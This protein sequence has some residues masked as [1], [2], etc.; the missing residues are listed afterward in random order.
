MP[1]FLSAAASASPTALALDDG[2][3]GWSYAALE[4][5]V[6]AAAGRLR[7]AAVA[8]RPVA[9][10]SE[11]TGDAVVA[12]HAALAAGA[13]L[14]PL[15]PRLTAEEMRPALETLRPR[16]VLAA[17]EA[18]D[19]ALAAGARPVPLGALEGEG[20]DALAERATA[21]GWPE[22]PPG[23]RVVLWTSGTGGRPRGVA[24]THENLEASIGAA[25]GR[26]ALGPDDR[27]LATL[28]IAH[29]GGLMLVLRAAATRALLI[30]RG[31]FRAGEVSALLDSAGV[32]HASLVPTMLRQLLDLR[33]DESPEA[34]RCLLIG[35]AHCP[36]SLVD[37]ALAAGFPLALT[38]GMTEATSQATTAAPALVR[39]K[40]G[41]VGSP[42]EGVE[43]RIDEAGEVL[44]R[45]ATVAA[46]YLGSELPLLDGEGWLRTGDLGELDSEGHLW[47]T[48]R[49]TDR[50]VTGGVN[51]D[52]LEVEDILRLHAG[53]SDAA[54]VGLPD[55]RWGEV[56]A[57]AVVRLGGAYPDPGELEELARARL[58][59]AKV[60]R[61]WLFLTELPKNQNGKIDRDA[62]RQGFATA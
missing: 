18:W 47:V 52:P 33:G 59:T 35:G 54:V 19:R 39:R 58:T 37:R 53:V 4:Q 13:V 6:S 23:T 17:P 26:L 31:R 2:E 24:L 48:G 38:Y 32:T 34:L 44:L 12:A 62:V 8:G 25:C 1:D 11:T 30:A 5:R 16:L 40:P 3:R 27:W 21:A 15:S 42:L 10:I 45:G 49:R 61:R 20:A 50:I 46:G 14:A 43:L 41:T 29:V 57:A 36:R 22:L 60:P 9:L 55:E 51:V 56:V 28:G 7:S